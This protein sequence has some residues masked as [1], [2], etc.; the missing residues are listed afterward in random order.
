MNN[1][2]VWPSPHVRPCL[3]ISRTSVRR[4]AMLE[5]AAMW[6]ASS[7]CCMPNRKPRPRIPNIRLLH[8]PPEA[9]VKQAQRRDRTLGRCRFILVEPPAADVR[10]QSQWRRDT[11]RR[12][13]RLGANEDIIPF[14]QTV[15]LPDNALE[16]A[17]AVFRR[18]AKS[19][20]RSRRV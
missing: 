17:A 8:H 1:V 6:S 14:V 18:Q 3:T 11:G 4:A 12:R 7:A 19:G 15:V 10:D 9:G 5:T 13:L 20:I 16:I 2:N